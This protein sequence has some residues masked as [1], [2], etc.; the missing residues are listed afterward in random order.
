MAGQRVRYMRASPVGVEGVVLRSVV[1]CQCVQ[2]RLERLT[3]CSRRS[4]HL[5]RG[6]RSS[7]GVCRIEYLGALICCGSPHPDRWE[8]GARLGGAPSFNSYIAT[9]P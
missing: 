3:A 8:L 4:S 1:M 9:V 6:A 2:Q 5:A 7:L